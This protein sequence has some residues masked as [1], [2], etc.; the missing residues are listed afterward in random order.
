M[1]PSSMLAMKNFIE[2][3]LDKNKELDIIDLGS[4]NINGT[5]KTLVESTKNWKYTGMDI[6]AGPN[7]DVVGWDNITKK[8]DVIISGQCLEHVNHPW[9]WLKNL[10]NYIKDDGI[11]CL[12]APHGFDEHRH[13]IDTYRYF[14]DGMRDLFNY[15]NIKELEIYKNELDTIGIGSFK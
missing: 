13:P 1:H 14:P 4:Y 8:Y 15:A 9:D 7:V 5:Y 12:I 2:K 6:E 10:K 11:L 3:Y